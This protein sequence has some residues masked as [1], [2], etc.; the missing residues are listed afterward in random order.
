M[1]G[2]RYLAR[3]RESI[4]STSDF[5]YRPGYFVSPSRPLWVLLREGLA[6]AA[7]CVC[8]SSDDVESPTSQILQFY[9]FKGYGYLSYGYQVPYYVKFNQCRPQQSMDVD[10]RMVFMADKGPGYVKSD[11]LA[12]EFADGTVSEIPAYNETFR[13]PRLNSLPQAKNPTFLH[14]ELP[15]DELAPFNSPNHGGRDQG[16]GQNTCRADGS[17]QYIKN[18]FA[19]VDGDNIYSARRYS[20]SQPELNRWLYTGMFP[21]NSNATCPGYRG[22]SYEA[23]SPTDTFL[24][25]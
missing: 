24:F 12:V 1:G 9:D 25:P 22:L 7:M 14:P 13:N 3:D 6:D 2:S 5:R 18:P 19:G 10:P 17:V 21:G 20:S 23:D 8:P 4:G 16:K 15:F 11:R